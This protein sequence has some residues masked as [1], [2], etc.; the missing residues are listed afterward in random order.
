[1]LELRCNHLTQIKHLI[2]ENFISVQIT[3]EESSIRIGIIEAFLKSD[4]RH[5]SQL[6]VHGG[7]LSISRVQVGSSVLISSVISDKFSKNVHGKVFRVSICGSI[8][9]NSNV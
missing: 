9:E 2:S 6:L 7:I 1:M 8:E 3:S 5:L 4:I